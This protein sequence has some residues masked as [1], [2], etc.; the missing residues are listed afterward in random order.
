MRSCRDEWNDAGIKTVIAIG[1]CLAPATIAIAVHSGH[2]Y[3]RNLDKSPEEASFFVVRWIL[4]GNEFKSSEKG[5][6]FD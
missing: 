2:E 6:Y 5:T 1:D 4:A 3:A